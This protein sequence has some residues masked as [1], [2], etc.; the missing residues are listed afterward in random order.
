[1]SVTRLG[2][3]R[4]QADVVA[5]EGDVERARPATSTA[6]DLVRAPRRARRASGTPPVCRP[7][8]TTPSSAVVAL[9]D[10]V[11]HAPDRPAHVVGVHDLG[12]GNEN[13]PVRGRRAA[14]AFGQ[15]GVLPVRAG[16]TGPASRSGVEGTTS[17][18]AIEPPD[19]AVGDEAGVPGDRARA[20]LAGS[21]AASIA[22]PRAHRAP[23]RPGDGR[24]GWPRGGRG[25]PPPP[26]DL[27]RALGVVEPVRPPHRPL[28]RAHRRPHGVA[29]SRRGDADRPPRSSGGRRLSSPPGRAG[30]RRPGVVA[31]RRRPVLAGPGAPA[32]RPGDARRPAGI[33]TAGPSRRRT[34]PSDQRR[35]RAAPRRGHRGP[36]SARPEPRVAPSSP[37]TTSS[38]HP[39]ARAQLRGRRRRRRTGSAEGARRAARRGR[40]RGTGRLGVPEVGRAHDHVEGI[41]DPR[42]REVLGQAVAALESRGDHHDG[43]RTAMTSRHEVD[44]PARLGPLGGGGHHRRCRSG[45]P[46]RRRSR[47][48]S[49]RR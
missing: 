38:P 33:G 47:R 28:R 45:R 12:P 36:R 49:P 34:S 21:Q 31:A 14:F 16:L 20:G 43:D 24:P 11:G 27:R 35:G 6:L 10:L 46:G 9:D 40:E 17:G 37:T 2:Q 1:M 25:G 48:T 19:R 7:T 4:A 42:A 30:P 15:A 41:V 23:S 8:S 3:D 13:A 29:P 44:V 5:V 26:A 39:E 32:R 22:P 18:P